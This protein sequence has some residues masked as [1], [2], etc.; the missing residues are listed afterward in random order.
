MELYKNLSGNSPVQSY[1]M[2]DDFITVK[3]PPNKAGLTTYIYNYF[4]TGQENV[5]TMKRLAEDGKGLAS[6]IVQYIG[7][8]YARRT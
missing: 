5:E 2:G 4:V 7:K 1:E 6:F 3:F 8:N